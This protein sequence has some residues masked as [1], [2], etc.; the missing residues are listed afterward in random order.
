[1]D[2]KRG[3]L[4]GIFRVGLSWATA[5]VFALYV[6]L[7]QLRGDGAMVAR[8]VAIG[9]TVVLTVRVIRIAIIWDD[10]SIVVRNALRSHTVNLTDVQG[11]SS[12]VVFTPMT[13]VMSWGQVSLETTTGRIPLMASV[14]R[15]PSDLRHLIDALERSAS[16]EEISVDLS[17]LQ[18]RSTVT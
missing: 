1:M 18:Q 16:P 12:Q 15:S 13:W 2:R 14:G 4:R 5:Y 9:L 11:V 7:D 6:A 3:G 10:S 8:M 17:R